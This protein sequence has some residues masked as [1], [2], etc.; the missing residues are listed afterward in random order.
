VRAHAASEALGSD[1]ATQGQVVANDSIVEFDHPT[2]GRIRQPRPAA[3][4]A[5]TPDEPNY[6]AP[7]PGEHTDE[8][9]SGAGVS[10]EE[11]VDLRAGGLVA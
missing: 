8:V 4:F 7:L 3:R 2:A 5:R 9:L 11:I 10:A 6:V 1:V